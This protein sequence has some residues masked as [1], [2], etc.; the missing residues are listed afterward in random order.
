MDNIEFLN[1]IIEK[2]RPDCTYDRFTNPIKPLKRKE[3]KLISDEFYEY[4]RLT[5]GF[6]YSILRFGNKTHFKIMKFLLEE[7]NFLDPKT[8]KLSYTRL[9]MALNERIASY[10]LE[11]S[12]KIILTFNDFGLDFTKFYFLNNYSSYRDSKMPRYDGNP[13]YYSPFEVA[14]MCN[15]WYIVEILLDYGLYGEKLAIDNNILE[16]CLRYKAPLNII[17]KLIDCGF[18]VNERYH[19]FNTPLKIAARNGDLE[20]VKLLVE[21][22]ANYMKYTKKLSPTKCALKEAKKANNNF[23]ASY[24]ENLINTNKQNK[25]LLKEN[26][27]EQKR[28]KKMKIIY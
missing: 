25:I 20:I 27:G 22:G 10:N 26:Y 24:L 8:C 9:G 2:I 28:Q 18:N 17:Q 16:I 7:N 13:Y 19:N 4:S 3:M 5:Y 1:C 6:L 23:V 11:I 14:V 21:N 12:K 15:E